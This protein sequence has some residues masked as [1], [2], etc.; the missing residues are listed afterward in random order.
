MYLDGVLPEAHSMLA[1]VQGDVALTGEQ[2][3]CGRCHRRSGLG[4]TEGHDVVPAVIGDILYNPLRLPTRK[5]PLAPELRPAYTDD[6][7]KR[8]IREGIGANGKPLGPLM[9]RYQL[10]DGQLDALL[11]F[12]KTLNVEPAPGVTD[13]EIHFATIVDASVAPG[14][15]KAFLDVFATF[16]DQKNRGTRHET[17]R[18]EHAP[19]HEA[20]NMQSYRKWVL[21]IWELD[22]PPESWRRQLQAHYDE[23]PVFAVI[24]GVGD[25]IWQPVHAFC[26]Q[27]KVPCLFPI[28]DLP[29]IDE[30]YFYTVYFSR[31]MALEADAVADHLAVGG[32]PEA[33]VV[34]VYRAG[35][36]RSE[37]AAAALRS[38]LS[39]QGGRITD[40][41][42]GTPE[43]VAD[44]FWPSVL[45]RAEGGAAVL[46]VD[47][48]DLGGALAA[49]VGLRPER[50]YLSSTLYGI[51][52]GRIAPE[53]L[54]RIYV[55]HAREMPA[56]MR[57]LLARSTGWLKA[58]G[59]Y[60]PG[61]PEVQSN[62]FFA[63]KIAGEAVQAMRQFY[64]RDYLLERI[65]HMMDNALYTSVFPRLTLAPGQRFV[66]KG[67]YIAQFAAQEGGNLTAVTPWRIP[68]FK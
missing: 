23:Q 52:P 55:V 45:A 8:A 29:V 68:A 7:L 10:S 37:S 33:P 60:A 38:R 44:D 19:W 54:G 31:G 1:I 27:S 59:I 16:F 63:L 65:E 25:G 18:A 5:P 22:G 3:V 4:S 46:W 48:E 56:G 17:N 28:T 9:P 57:V 15:R 40:I 14:T 13:R 21:H 32:R 35:D 12:L 41:V 11:A 34:Q 53:A 66:S 58:N 49:E 2:V 62:A 39:G 61:A 47:A 30:R 67:A 6:T 51:E 26:E 64:V 36:P 24:S 43:A 50:V 42:L 20:W